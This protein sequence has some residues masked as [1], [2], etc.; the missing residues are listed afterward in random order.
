MPGLLSCFSLF[1]VIVFADAWLFCTVVNLVICV[2]LDLLYIFVVVSPGFDF[3]FSLLVKCGWEEHLQTN[4]YCVEWNLCKTLTQSINLC[5]IVY[6][7][8]TQW[9]AHTSVLTVAYWFRFWLVFCMFLSILMKA[10]LLLCCLI[11]LSVLSFSFFSPKPI[12]W[13]GRTSP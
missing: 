1:W 10:I 3:V 12:D 6:D 7:S 11:L 13:L 5:C 9:Y 8:C 2:S 4:L